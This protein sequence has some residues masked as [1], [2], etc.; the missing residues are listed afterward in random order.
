MCGLKKKKKKSSP[1]E[2]RF[3]PLGLSM[4]TQLVI[5]SVLTFQNIL[6]YSKTTTLL[7]LG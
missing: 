5:L 1:D 2:V 6:W 3:K 7:M 4:H